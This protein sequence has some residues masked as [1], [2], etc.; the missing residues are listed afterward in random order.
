MAREFHSVGV[1]GLGIQGAGVAEVF[2][3]AGVHVVGVE[4]DADGIAH[5][6]ARV[7]H[8]TERAVAGGKLTGAERAELLGRITYSSELDDLAGCDL[9]VEAV[10]ENLDLKAGVF[11]RL[12]KIPPPETILAT[13]TSSL[14]VTEIGV[15]T[16]RPERVIGMHF[17]NPAPVLRFVEVV[18]TVVTEPN[19]ITDVEDLLRKVG[20]TALVI[21]DRAGFL[22]NSL[23]FS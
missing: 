20:N 10:T 22:A 9:V 12:D 6:R 8:S 17:F 21:G 16:G 11:A 15:H 13:N 1:V 3:R 5:G 18:R 7:E 4:V 23:L 14:S 19:V 2:A